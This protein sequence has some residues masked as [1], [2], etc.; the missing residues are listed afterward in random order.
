MALVFAAMY[1]YAVGF[2][3][4]KNLKKIVH[5]FSLSGIDKLD[6]MVNDTSMS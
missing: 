6:K 1:L 3:F 2:G 5:S 4:K